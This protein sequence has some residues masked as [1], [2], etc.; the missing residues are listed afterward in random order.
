MA[1]MTIDEALVLARGHL[2][3]GRLA[4]GDSVCQ[5][6][7]QVSPREFDAHR[8]LGLLACAAGKTT[9]AETH[10][11]AAL[12][13][14][15]DSAEAHLALCVIF[16]S[17][18]QFAEAEQCARQA[19]AL[20]PDLAEA[21]NNLGGALQGQGKLDAAVAAFR[22]ALAL[23]PRFHQAGYNLGFVLQ[24]QEK[25]EDAAI[26]YEQALAIEPAL[27][28][29][30]NNLGLVRQQQGRLKLAVEAYR[31]ALVRQPINPT[32]AYN[33]GLALQ[34]LGCAD[35]AIEA[36]RR[37]VDQQPNLYDAANNLGSLLH[38]RGRPDE[39]ILAYQ[40]ALAVKPDFAEAESN[41][42]NSLRVL[43][44]FR[45]AI[46]AYGRALAL[47]PDYHEAH[48]NLGLAFHA[49]GRLDEAAECYRR[50]LALRPEFVEAE[51]NL[52][53]VLLAQGDHEPAMAAY[54]R[55]LEIRPIYLA[56]HSNLLMCEQYRQGATLAG[57]ARAHAEWEERHAAPLRADWRPHDLDRDPERRLRIGFVSPDLRRHPV[58]FFLVRV[59]ENLDKNACDVVCYHSRADRDDYSD[60]LAAVATE[61]HDVLGLANDALADQIRD[62]RIDI[63]FDLSGHSADHRLLVFARRPAPIQISWIGYVG[64]TGLTAMDYLLA[65]RWQVPEGVEAHYRE[66]VLRMPNGYVCFEPPAEAPEVGPLPA[67][68]RGPFTFGSFNNLSKLTPEVIALWAKVVLRVPGSRLV[69][70]SPALGGASARKRIEGAFEAAG[71]EPAR[72]ELCGTMLR[73]DMLAAYN[74]V[75][76]A[77]DP[78]PYSGGVTTCEALWMGVPVLTCP[79]ETFAGRHSLSHLANVGLTET[80]ARDH[81]DYIERAAC[82]AEDLPRLAAIRAGLRDRM[83]RS[84]LCDGERFAGNLTVLLRDVW[85]Q[86][87]RQ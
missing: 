23:R 70:V 17:R 83:A 1:T 51:N 8:L 76:L 71:V 74:S 31:R 7:L 38:D 62:D 49:T 46:A 80:I 67:L 4:D 75:D 28:E 54:C 24:N 42:G 53:N 36:Y 61:W 47:R 41:L 84:P 10:V 72:L 45:E 79:G 40:H 26:A 86:W 9:R 85:R 64:T 33:L 27:P 37:A 66:K 68:A 56:A 2:Q 14:R 59:L 19:L 3:A 63:L 77:L 12:A 43:G 81:Q 25:W 6:I 78:F 22:R 20:R 58:G 21:E 11:R 50:S 18:S 69:L 13:C 29:A 82:L 60:R 87:C 30:E 48:S 15:P 16:A 44:R 52:G 34:S 73:P 65:D 35:E 32:A 5:A 39:A 57:L 55:A